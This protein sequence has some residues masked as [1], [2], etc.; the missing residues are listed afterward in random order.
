MKSRF[1]FQILL[2]IATIHLIAGC[3]KALKNVEDYNPIVEMESIELQ[4]DGS[5][6]LIGNIISNGKFKGATSDYAGFCFTTGTNGN[7]TLNNNQITGQVEGEKIV[8]TCPV[9]YFHEDSTYNI[10]A[11]TTNNITYAVSS[12]MKASNLVIDVTPTCT[13]A[14]NTMRTNNFTYHLGDA[15]AYQS[16][17]TYE[18]T[19]SDG[20]HRVILEFKSPLYSNVFTT[21][22]Y[23]DG[24]TT[25]KAIVYLDGES[26]LLDP[27]QK[28]YVQKIGN[29]YEI[30]ICEATY[31]FFST[32]LKLTAKL[33]TNM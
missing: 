28:V 4:P 11:W 14:D 3:T 15:E 7:P 10:S 16:F 33:V 26:R 17:D 31:K 18:I 5:V 25:V 6:K 9:G 32:S 22:D 23:V 20:P 27:G 21:N 29:N 1:F 13:P 19:G 24:N 2:V 8:A 12:P 30:T